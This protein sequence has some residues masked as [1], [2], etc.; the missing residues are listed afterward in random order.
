M[1]QNP[2]ATISSKGLC[3]GDSKNIIT[4]LCAMGRVCASVVLALC[5]FQVSFVMIYGTCKHR[6]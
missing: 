5:V 2:V 6:M 1:M 3:V 4:F